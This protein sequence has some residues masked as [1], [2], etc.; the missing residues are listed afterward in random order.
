MRPSTILPAALAATLT[1]AAPTKRALPPAFFLAGDSTTATNGGWGDAFVSSLTSGST[2]QN[3]GDSGATTGS[4]R[5][6]GYWADV[7]AAVES[8]ADEYTPYVTI[9]FGHNDQKTESGL[10]AFVDN[11]VQFDADVRAAGGVPI[12]LTSLTRRNFESDGTLRQDL[13][14]VKDLTIEAAGET[15][16]LWADLNEASREYVSAIGED[17]SHTYNLSSGDNTHINKEGEVVFAGIV[18]LLLK[19]LNAE[20]DEF[21]SVDP[22]LVAALEQGEYYYPEL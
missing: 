22:E 11:L 12:F 10:A 2:G 9:Q 18:A 16:A 4:F 19:E 1:S 17:N 15:G 7:L 6:E 21:I 5:N 20:F 14:N 8:H 13:Q 3:F